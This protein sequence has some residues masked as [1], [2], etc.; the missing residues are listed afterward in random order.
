MRPYLIPMAVVLMAAAAL[1][2]Q[3]T[4]YSGA[5]FYGCGPFVPRLTTPEISFQ[6]VSPNPTGASNATT[7]LIAGATNST[8][9]QVEGSTSSVYTEAV[10][11]QGGAPLVT[12]EVHI[13]P[14]PIGRE[15]RPAFGPMREEGAREEHGPRLEARA[16]WN[17]IA[18]EYTPSVATVAGVGKGDKKADHVY[19]NE[20]VTRQNQNNGVVKYRGKTEKI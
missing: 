10:W 4:P 20:D 2:Q 17:Y 11:Y 1:A 6:Q 12:P 15:A 13:W 16:G 7:G 8:L 14:Q 19:N 9:S 3:P 5:C 18:E